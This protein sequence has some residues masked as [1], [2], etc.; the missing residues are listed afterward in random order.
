[1]IH[2]RTKFCELHFITYYIGSDAVSFTT[3]IFYYCVPRN[4]EVVLVN[5]SF[6]SLNWNWNTEN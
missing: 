3:S 2:T 5:G 1:M 4:A 6:I